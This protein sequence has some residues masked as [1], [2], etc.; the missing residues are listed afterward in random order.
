M[1]SPRQRVTQWTTSSGEAV[2]AGLVVT[3]LV[4][5]REK[6]GV[7]F[8]PMVNRPAIQ[9]AEY[10][11]GS[12]LFAHLSFE[13]VTPAPPLRS[14]ASSDPNPD[15]IVQERISREKETLLQ[16]L[17]HDLQRAFTS[18]EV[19]GISSEQSQLFLQHILASSTSSASSLL[20]GQQVKVSDV[21]AGHCSYC[22]SYRIVSYRIVH[23]KRFSCTLNRSNRF[24]WTCSPPP[25]TRPAHRPPPSPPPRCLWHRGCRRSVVQS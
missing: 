21:I 9:N 8:S 12:H 7:F 20:F 1:A 18:E 2:I 25:L 19:E 6:C 24:H 5:G 10:V 3:S 13:G 17:T 22:S 16:S 11:T 14:C 15:V 23:R 4:Y